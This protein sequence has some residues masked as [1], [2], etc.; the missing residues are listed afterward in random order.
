MAKRAPLAVAVTKRL[1]NQ[2]AGPHFRAAEN[3]M[4]AIFGSADVEE[5]RKAFEER[6][7]PVYEGN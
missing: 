1:L 5:G 7:E 3:L 6:R 2:N 4:P